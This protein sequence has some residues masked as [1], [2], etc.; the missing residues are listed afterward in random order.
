MT[1]ELP[2]DKLLQR[3]RYLDEEIEGYFAL[4]LEQAKQRYRLVKYGSKVNVVDKVAEKRRNVENWRHKIKTNY[5]T[6]EGRFQ[7]IWDALQNNPELDLCTVTD[8]LGNTRAFQIQKLGISLENVS[9]SKHEISAL[10]SNTEEFKLKLRQMNLTEESY[11][12]FLRWQEN[13]CGASSEIY[14]Q[15]PK[16]TWNNYRYQWVGNGYRVTIAS[17]N[18]NSYAAYCKFYCKL[19]TC[20]NQSCKFLHDATKVSVCRDYLTTGTCK[21]GQRCRLTH[22]GGS[23]FVWPQCRK[24]AEQKCEF[25]LGAEA[26]L[27]ANETRCLFFHSENVNLRFP[28]CR[29]FAHMGYCYRGLSCPFPHFLECPDSTYTPECFLIHCKYP[30]RQ[31]NHEITPSSVP[32]TQ[33]PCEAYL[34]PPLRKRDPLL[35]SGT[36]WYGLR[37]ATQPGMARTNAYSDNGKMSEMTT[38]NLPVSSSD[39]DESTTTSSESP[40]SSF[41]GDELNADF[42]KI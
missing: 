7:K 37:P 23:E 41:S 14:E 24:F 38:L 36:S 30:H 18:L 22:T 11:L 33:I 42:I 20:T 34:L 8:R 4:N 40:E 26:S 27:H 9:L 5:S 25:Q 2:K 13:I 35:A 39:E 19:G 16:L 21:Y 6:A 31:Q 3:L 17:R 32:L 12:S 10:G 1:T 28:T 29:Q 15:L